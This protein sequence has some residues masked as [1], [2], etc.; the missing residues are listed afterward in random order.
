MKTIEI[1]EKLKTDE[2]KKYLK[3]HE[4]VSKILDL[5]M[6]NSKLSNKQYEKFKNISNNCEIDIHLIRM[7]LS[8]RLWYNDTEL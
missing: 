3:Y 6:K 7:E 4:N 1:Y 5:K 8:K 2:L